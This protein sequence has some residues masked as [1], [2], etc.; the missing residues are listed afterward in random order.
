[1]NGTV[2]LENSL[3]VSSNKTKRASTWLRYPEKLKLMHTQISV[4]ECL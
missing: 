1:M 2:T 4:D 3:L